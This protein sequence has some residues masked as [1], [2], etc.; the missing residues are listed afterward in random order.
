MVSELTSTLRSVQMKEVL[1]S[2]FFLAVAILM[3]VTAKYIAVDE[4]SNSDTS[5]THLLSA[6]E[7]G[8]P[9]E[10]Q[11]PGEFVSPTPTIEPTIAPTPD[12]GPPPTSMP[13]LTPEFDPNS[14][15]GYYQ[16]QNRLWKNGSEVVLRGVSWFGF[17]TEIHVVHGL[18]RRSYQD[19]IAQIKQTG[20]NAVRLPFCPDTLRGTPT[21]HIKADLN[22][23]LVGKDSL[24]TLDII[25]NEL[26]EQ[27][28]YIML[29]QH[30]PNCTDQS[31]LWYT[32]YYSEDQWI[33]DLEFISQRYRHLSFFI[34]ID[35]KNEPYGATWGT[36]NSKTDWKLASE[37]A[38]QAILNKNPHL[39]IFVQ[40]I[41]RNPTCVESSGHFWGENL[42]PIRCYP[43]DESAVPKHKVVYSP[44]V[45]GPDV[46]PQPYFNAA[47]FPNN[48]PGLWESHFGFL[49][50]LGYTIVPGEWGGKYGN[51]GNPKDKIWQDTFVDYMINRGICSSFY[52]SWNPNSGDTGGVL[53]DDWE[54]VWPNKLQLFQK[55]FSQCS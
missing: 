27:G 14:A 33:N 29:D 1:A 15:I 48:M 7:N 2:A 52:W 3:V 26:N 8:V 13:T 34:G 38:G 4:V 18:W 21:D 5:Y 44:H 39:L 23:A 28:M 43:L 36:G 10:V 51:G 47:N 41:M 53:S 37:K 42:E 24:E 50:D 32:T 11:L 17:E 49:H 31:P 6:Q 30:R 20:F 16:H 54:T 40:G 55:Y 12:A 35:I 25:M 22:P 45:Y 46:Y 9:L 19:M